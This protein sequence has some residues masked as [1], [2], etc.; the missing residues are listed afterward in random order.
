MV[1]IAYW[2]Q[3]T[4]KFAPGLCG[5]MSQLPCAYIISVYTVTFLNSKQAVLISNR[6]GVHRAYLTC[7][8]W[9][10]V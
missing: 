3:K 10:S 5:S 7:S 8:L 6:P 2:K 9:T 1:F 4:V